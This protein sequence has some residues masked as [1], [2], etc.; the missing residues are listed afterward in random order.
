MDQKNKRKRKR[1]TNKL[2]G[3]QNNDTRFEIIFKAIMVFV[4]EIFRIVLIFSHIC[5]LL[6]RV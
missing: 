2:W 1:K 6:Y 4:P 5:I 3:K